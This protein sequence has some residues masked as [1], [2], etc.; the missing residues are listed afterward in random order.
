MDLPALMASI[1]DQVRKAKPIPLTDQVRLDKDQMHATLDE[2]RARCSE[3]G[4]TP[5]VPLI[6]ELD[7]EIR[8]AR[9]VPLTAQV[10]L[11]KPE[12]E[13]IAGEIR[14][15]VSRTEV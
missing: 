8:T 14:A 7:E 10:R 12:L 13:K 11:P 5:V 3:E 2:M 1:D 4:L 6:D 15:H 9:P